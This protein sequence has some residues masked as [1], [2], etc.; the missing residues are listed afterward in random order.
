MPATPNDQ[1]RALLAEARLNGAALARAVNQ[2]ADENGMSLAYGRAAVSQWLRG[3]HPRRPVPQLIAEVLSRRLDR[4]ITP[5]AA[6]FGN[7]RIWTGGP[8]QYW[9][10]DPLKQ[11]AVLAPS[12]SGSHLG[13][14]KLVYSKAALRIPAWAEIAVTAVHD[15]GGEQKEHVGRAEV[16]AVA[17]MADMFAVSDA[18][19]G[20]GP[21]RPAA[22]GYLATP[23]VDWLHASAGTRIRPSLYSTAARLTCLCGYLCFDDELHGAAQR[24]FHVALALAAEAGDPTTYAIG[25]RVLSMQA[26]RLGHHQE[27]LNLAHAALQTPAPAPPQTQALLHSEAAVAHAATGDR[28]GAQHHLRTAEVRLECDSRPRI[29]VGTYHPADHAQQQATAH[30]L[31]GERPT[32]INDLKDSIRRRSAVERRARTI[33]LADLAELQLACGRLDQA[34]ETW[35]LFMDNCSTVQCGRVRTALRNMRSSLRSHDGYP[36]ARVLLHR[37]APTDRPN[38]GT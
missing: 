27:A 16:A 25:L 29:A 35:H 13:L 9:T 18:L 33:A 7:G 6:G 5:D 36:P 30:S 23:V 34:I 15:H 28:A 10:D 38:G 17:A 26:R 22:S 32:A 21:V 4:T 19:T 20:A 3:S 24:Y 12:A 8:L 14:E 37:T 2:L 31:L 1:L 11:L